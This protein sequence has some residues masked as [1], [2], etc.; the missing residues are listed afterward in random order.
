MPCP[1][2]LGISSEIRRASREQGFRREESSGENARWEPGPPAPSLIN[3]KHLQHPCCAPGRPGGSLF[4][5]RFPRRCYRVWRKGRLLSTRRTRRGPAPLVPRV[6]GG[7][8]P[9]DEIRIDTRVLTAS[10]SQSPALPA[11]TIAAECEPAVTPQAS[12]GK[13]SSL[14][15]VKVF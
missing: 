4:E 15:L 5:P 10:H 1:A 12:G 11:S 13:Q 8:S 3:R 14:I 9:V 2:A 6:S 7:R